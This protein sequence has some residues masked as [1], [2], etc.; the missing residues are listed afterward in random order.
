MTGFQ[1]RLAQDLP[2]F[3]TAAGNPAAATGIN[4][5]GLRRRGFTPER[6]A[7]IKQMHRLLYR[8]RLTLADA[9][10]RIDALRGAVADGD[11]DVAL[12]LGFLAGAER[13]IVR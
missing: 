2:P 3:V 10:E 5:E 13:G 7:G 9:R 4:Q 8:Q 1:T 6:I 12:M 11:D